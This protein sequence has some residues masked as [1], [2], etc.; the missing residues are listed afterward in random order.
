MTMRDD[1]FNPRPGRIRHGNQGAKRPKRFVAE[2]M[3]AAKKAGHRGRTFGPRG[4]SGGRSTFGRGRRAALSLA[5]RSSGRR[6]IV[7]GRIVRHRGG[8][9][10]SVPLSKH[11]AYLKPDGVTRDG[12]DARSTLP[13]TTPTRWLS[14]NGALWTATI[15]VSQSLRRMRARWTSSASSSPSTE[16]RSSPS[17]KSM[18]GDAPHRGGFPAS[19]DRR[20]RSKR[21]CPSFCRRVVRNGHLPERQIMTG[22]G[23]VAVRRPRLRDREAGATI[24]RASAS[25]RQSC[26]PS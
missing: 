19:L 20:C 15:F 25:P 8:R 3:R 11:V 10:R 5:S 24:R 9:F 21:K 18:R 13:P 12:A 7:M 22:I 17:S 14:Q 26:H 6:V 23:P 4:A 2:V 1:D 16:R